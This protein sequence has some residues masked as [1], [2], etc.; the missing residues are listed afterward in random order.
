MNSTSA[1]PLIRLPSAGLVWLDGRPSATVERF[2]WRSIFEIRAVK[3]PLYG[4]TGS[5]TW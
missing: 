5:T 1:T 4:P 3:S 2:P